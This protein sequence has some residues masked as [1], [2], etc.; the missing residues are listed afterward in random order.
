MLITKLVL[1]KYKRLMLNRISHYEITPTTTYQLII[2]TNG[3]GKTSVMRELSPMPAKSSDYHRDGY[4]IIEFTH[5]G[6]VYVLESTFQNG[7][8]HSF[9]KDGI[10]LNQGGTETVQKELILAHIGLDS[11]I[12]AILLDEKRL[13]DMSPTQRRDI[14]MMLAG[15]NLDYAMQIYNQMR[16][17]HRDMQGYVKH[18]TKRMADEANSI[19]SHDEVV[20]L[21]RQCNAV[22]DELTFLMEN[23]TPNTPERHAL[24]QALT[25]RM[26]NIEGR[27]M[28][29]IERL[30]GRWG[31]DSNKGIA[32]LDAELSFLAEAVAMEQT[33]INVYHEEHSKINEL[34]DAMR[35]VKAEGLKD[36]EHK[37]KAVMERYREVRQQLNGE[38]PVPNASEC[39]TTLKAIESSI[40]DIFHS[41]PVN[42]EGRY[43]KGVEATHRQY[44]AQLLEQLDVEKERAVRV[45]HRIEHIDKAH[46]INCPRCKFSWLD[47]V[48][49][50]ELDRNKAEVERISEK[51]TQLQKALGEANAELERMMEYAGYA[52]RMGDIMRANS[53]LT[54]LWARVIEAWNGGRSPTQVPAAILRWK[55]ILQASIELQQMD[56]EVADIDAAYRHVEANGISDAS[57]Y[58]QRLAELEDAISV[59]TS[60]LMAYQKTMQLGRTYRNAVQKAM[61][62]EAELQRDMEAFYRDL[63]R[64]TDSIRNERI[65]TLIGERHTSLAKME[66]SLSRA[67]TAR[68]LIDELERSKQ[69]AVLDIE[70]MGMLVNELSPTDG[71]I[72]EQIYGFLECLTD[73]MN[74]ILGQIWTYDFHVLPNADN[75]EGELDY[76][77]PM[78]VNGS[79]LLVRDIA[80]GSASQVD[81]VN[82]AFKLVAMMYMGMEDFPLYLDELA[83][84]L[85]EQHRLNIVMFVKS[86]VE[87]KRCSQMWMISHYAVQSGA[88]QPS[89]TCVMDTANIVSMPETFNQHVKMG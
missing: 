29:I 33:K 36:I 6:S 10:P 31:S 32:D 9:T 39:L 50:G 11:T 3:C 16:T 21:E 73:Q 46:K 17:K 76:R 75:K 52:R 56:S 28:A 72:G 12:L 82:F 77:F 61:E 79:E 70:A 64:L 80:N 23:R 38:E 59:H 74:L 26:R 7:P 51:I 54:P 60:A 87:T 15:G 44:I 89:Q 4:K 47:G 27:S 48:A 37:R 41:I 43:G 57:Y 34:V 5:R 22:K 14:L 13:T 19:P 49:D 58:V 35:K 84:S 88:F 62:T 83:P 24:E 18:L 66:E 81:A 1:H 65:M 69:E 30:S 8:H 63:D 55:S 67:K 86:F 68:A 20:E 40:E 53:I 25:Q 2:G 78:R 71:L 85:D 45:R 42:H